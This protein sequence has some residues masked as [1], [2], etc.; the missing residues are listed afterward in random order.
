MDSTCS[1]HTDTSGNR[2][3]RRFDLVRKKRIIAI[4]RPSRFCWYSMPWALRSYLTRSRFPTA[5]V[6]YL[7]LAIVVL[8][9]KRAPPRAG[10]PSNRTFVAVIWVGTVRSNRADRKNESLG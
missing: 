10:T 6:L 1:R 4:F 3:F 8:A 2:S 7:A 5:V 9:P